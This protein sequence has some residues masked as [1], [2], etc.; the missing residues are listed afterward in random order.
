MNDA[1]TNN[2][3]VVYA[4][5]TPNP[6]AIKFVIN[7]PLLEQG[8]QLEFPSVE[9]TKGAPLAKQLFQFPF[10]K[11]IFIS[12]NYITITKA[13]G[14]EWSDI[15]NELRDFIKNYFTNGGI[16]LDEVPTVSTNPSTLPNSVIKSEIKTEIDMRIV[17]ILNEY[18]KPAVEQ[19]G[20]AITFKSFNEG[21]V[22]VAL[23]GSCSG[24]PSSQ[25][26]LKAGIEALLKRMV[27][28]VNE[29]VAEAY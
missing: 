28:E 11:N 12:T 25:M 6:N 23:Q 1:Q 24:C 20:G 14:I 18:I 4:E 7:Q 26:T 27:P 17:D 19:D 10:V 9:F 16:V 21:L 15:M 8:I 13:I 5:Q 2:S 29:V 3:I 22:T